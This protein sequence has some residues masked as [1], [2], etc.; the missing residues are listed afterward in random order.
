[1]STIIEDLR[2][3]AV[4]VGDT[5]AYAAHDGRSTGMRIGTVLEIVE[6]G[7]RPS[8][9]LKAYRDVPTM[10]KVRVEHS[11]RDDSAKVRAR[12]ISV[13]HADMKRFVKV[14]P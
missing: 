10:L 14:T 6:A 9:H 11:N 13:I 1:M 7:R 4:A 2:G 3:E 8:K 5:I 12:S